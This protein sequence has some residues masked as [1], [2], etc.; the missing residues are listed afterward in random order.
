MR[1]DNSRTR[2]G[3]SGALAGGLGGGSAR[4][5][6][7][8]RRDAMTDQWERQAALDAAG[9]NLDLLPAAS[10]DIDMVTD[11]LRH[12][13][14]CLH[15]LPGGLLDAAREGPATAQLAS[16]LLG[17]PCVIPVT[18]GRF[19]EGLLNRALLSDG[20]YVLGSPA[21]PTAHTHQVLSGGRPQAVV[22]QIA[23]G[24]GTAFAGDLDLRALEALIDELGPDNVG[25]VFLE[26]CT[27]ALGG[28]P[29][30]MDSLGQVRRIADRYGLTVYLDGTRVLDNVVLIKARDR[31]YRH[32]PE[33]QILK[34]L[35]SQ[36]DACTLSATKNFMTPAGGLLACWDETLRDACFDDYLLFGG[37]PSRL[38]QACMAHG[39]GDL[40]GAIANVRRRGA[41]VRQLH[42]ALADTYAAVTPPG[43]H[44]VYLDLRRSPVELPDGDYPEYSFLHH[45]YHRHG[46]RGS[47][48]QR[49]DCGGSAVP[50]MIRLALP[51]VGFDRR[52]VETVADR[53]KSIV[54]QAE[55]PASIVKVH[56]PPGLSGA[57]RATFAPV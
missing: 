51:V 41:L 4:Q 13:P 44:A 38:D 28:Q 53:L 27:N 35:M 42:A 23:R 52:T 1:D 45:L 20:Q 54:A 55:R 16:D 15:F 34:E 29:I 3:R 22:P 5:P 26:P 57:F 46:I 17:M 19:A 47:F 25:Y 39:L 50:P 40:D 49:H 30:S 18:Q 21:F 56:Q 7:Q 6:D 10:V 36:V 31:G 14:D 37:E 12:V 48:V 24:S 11:S 8:P 33:G 32:S 43:G 9:H 2:T